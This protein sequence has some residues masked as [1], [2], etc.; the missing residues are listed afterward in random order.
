M[1]KQRDNSN[2]TAFKV[3]V[4]FS[5]HCTMFRQEQR[6]MHYVKTQCMSAI[7]VF[8]GQWLKQQ[9]F[10]YLGLKNNISQNVLW[11]AT[12]EEGASDHLI[13]SSWRDLLNNST[14]QCFRTGLKFSVTGYQRLWP[15]WI[16][17]SCLCRTNTHS[18]FACW[19]A[20]VRC[21]LVTAENGTLLQPCPSLSKGFTAPNPSTLGWHLLLTCWSPPGSTLSAEGWEWMGPQGHYNFILVFKLCIHYKKPAIC[22][23]MEESDLSKI[24]LTCTVDYYH[25]H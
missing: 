15:T 6:T 25:S 20:P 12:G 11:R 5:D 9:F 19:A 2:S 23:F 24:P 8:S 4:H 1:A 18:W 22:G 14:K 10:L 16:S 3:T 21:D 17:L 13:S 7:C